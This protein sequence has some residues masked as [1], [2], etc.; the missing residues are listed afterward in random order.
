MSDSLCCNA[1]INEQFHTCGECGQHAE[2]EADEEQDMEV[3]RLIARSGMLMIVACTASFVA[4]YFVAAMEAA[5]M[6][7]SGQ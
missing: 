1:P 6:V 5:Q 2:P 3:N 7:R 4:G